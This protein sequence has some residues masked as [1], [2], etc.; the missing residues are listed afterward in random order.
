MPNLL[1][2]ILNAMSPVEIAASVAGLLCVWL[3]VRANIWNWFWGIVNV[4]LFAYIFWKSSL[5][6]SMLL[7]LLYFLPM[8]F[9]GWWM[10]KKGGPSQDDDLPVSRLSPAAGVV[11]FL[12]AS[13]FTMGWGL[14]MR[15]QG[16]AVP[17]GDAAATALSIVAQYL[18][19]RKVVESWYFWI[20]VDLLYAL[21]VLPSQ[22]L[23]VATGLYV[24]FLGMATAGAIE[25]YRLWKKQQQQGRIAVGPEP[26]AAA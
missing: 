5:Y 6:S 17:F 11:S 8:Q 25:W 22:K 26:M 16:G 15:S 10:W 24:I 9:Y 20:A 1:Q 21:Y 12:V 7:Q 14:F 18:Q 2:T 4:S 13:A 19:A 23:W 3:V